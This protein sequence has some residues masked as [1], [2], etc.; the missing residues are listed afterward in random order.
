METNIKDIIQRIDDVSVEVQRYIYDTE[1][2]LLYWLPNKEVQDFIK[3]YPDDFEDKVHLVVDY[4]SGSCQV[5]IKFEDH[6]NDITSIQ[7]YCVL[8]AFRDSVK[9]RY[10]EY[11]GDIKKYQL[12]EIKSALKYYKRK[13]EEMENKLKAMEE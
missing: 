9:A 13:V 3:E 6:P 5:T 4:V 1:H 2:W 7:R 11:K 8:A 12:K 10:A